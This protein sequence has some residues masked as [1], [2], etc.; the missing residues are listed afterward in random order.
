MT[1]DRET[2]EEKAMRNIMKRLQNHTLRAMLLTLVV[3]PTL[4]GAAL[5]Q[6]TPT[7]KGQEAPLVAAENPS[8]V[9]TGAPCLIVKHK[10]TVGRRLIFTALIGVPIAPGAKYDLVD[11]VNYNAP[12]VAFTGKEL[13]KAQAS[14]VHVIV[15][16]KKYTQGDA[17]AARRSC[18]E[19]A[20]EQQQ[21][22]AQ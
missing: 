9:P 19:P 6:E 4:A 20:S 10:G 3:V 7:N 1:Q 18:G 13:Q 14:G 16:E 17:E 22:S 5:A 11:T 8:T 12:K 15:L 21:Q 2:R